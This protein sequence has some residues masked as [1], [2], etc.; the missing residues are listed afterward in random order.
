MIP[1]QSTYGISVAMKGESHEE[2][3]Q[4]LTTEE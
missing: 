1:G 2:L 4:G 3:A